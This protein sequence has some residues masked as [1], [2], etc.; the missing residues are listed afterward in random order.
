MGGGK[1]CRFPPPLAHFLAVD[2]SV[3]R[4][5]GKGQTCG[6][7]APVKTFA[8]NFER[9]IIQSYFRL[10]NA[11]VASSQ[12]LSGKR[13]AGRNRPPSSRIARRKGLAEES[14]HR[15]ALS[16]LNPKR[17][18]AETADNCHPADTPG[19]PIIING[20][21]WSVVFRPVHRGKGYTTSKSS[22][23][24]SGGKGQWANQRPV[25]DQA[26]KKIGVSPW[27][28][29]TEPS[30]M[31]QDAQG[32]CSSSLQTRYTKALRAG[33]Q[34]VGKTPGLTGPVLRQFR[35]RFRA[36]RRAPS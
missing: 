5:L 20:A 21:R 9:S 27:S 30:S 7:E 31:F 17:P 18:A 4:V 1:G 10:A 6:I 14:G 8:G 34:L 23:A 3:S 35:E 32:P 24:K 36:V 22:V 11:G 16:L 28:V 12:L 29:L 13:R 15:A 33:D 26:W 2:K 25:G 19:D